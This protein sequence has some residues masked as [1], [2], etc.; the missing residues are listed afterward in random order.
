MKNKIN[1][2]N[3]ISKLDKTKNRLALSLKKGFFAFL[4]STIFGFFTL[5]ATSAN[6]D[7]KDAK[8]LVKKLE[9]LNSMEADFTQLSIDGKGLRVQEL[10][11]KAKIQRPNLMWWK[12]FEPYEQ[13]MV[14][15]GEKI[16]F[17]EKDLEQVSVKKLDPK[18]STTPVLLLFEDTKN[19]NKSFYVE[20]RKRGGIETFILDPKVKDS[21]FESLT[22]TFINSKF[23]KLSL[24]DS[25]NQKTIISFSKQNFGAKFKKSDFEFKIPEGV[26]VIQA[27]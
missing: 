19:I 15:N 17:Y 14:T 5:F 24:I 4:L 27:D 22:L 9:I 10:K 8:I 26:D 20:Y 12:T 23:S 3:K 2:I 18:S 13:L 11:G 25:L 16:W 6:A 1:K 21:L 7:A